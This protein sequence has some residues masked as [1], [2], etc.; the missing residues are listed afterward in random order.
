MNM[1]LTAALLTVLGAI[2]NADSTQSGATGRVLQ[3]TAALEQPRGDSPFMTTLPPGVILPVVGKQGEWYL[4]EV[5]ASPGTRRAWVHWQT[6]EIISGTVP[7]ATAARPISPPVP[8][9]VEIPPAA[10][11][12]TDA[13]KPTPVPDAAGA[14]SASGQA[15][16][17][18]VA[19]PAAPSE[20]KSMAATVALWFIVPGGGNFYNGATGKG[21]IELAG[22][23]GG[24]ALMATGFH[25]ECEVISRV[26]YCGDEVSP[27]QFWGGFSLAVGTRI[28]GLISAI[29][30]TSGINSGRIKAFQ[31]IRVIVP[32]K[33]QGFKVA[34][35]H[36]F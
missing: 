5:Q 26:T 33:K 35:V 7:E 21:V 3:A 2:S 9:S 29:N 16:A 14:D 10:M 20:K 4:V 22:V 12:V 24:I 28:W 13:S 18:P 6:I 30:R 25:E 15:G 23:V 31:R 34:Y 32:T 19:P 1:L 27:G 11:P 36:R 8:R 17:R